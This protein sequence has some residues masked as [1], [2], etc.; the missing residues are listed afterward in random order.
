MPSP[1]SRSPESMTRSP[2]FF[3]RAALGERSDCQSIASTSGLGLAIDV[4]DDGDISQVS[5]RVD[6]CGL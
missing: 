2:V 3:D 5:G 1:R 6:I 4:R